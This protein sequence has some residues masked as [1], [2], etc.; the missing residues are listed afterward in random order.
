[1]IPTVQGGSHVDAVNRSIT[2][3][4]NSIGNK[5]NL[6]PKDNPLKVGDIKDGLAVI[7]S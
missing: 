5:L 1:M 6:I 4:L 2:K 3:I 7:I